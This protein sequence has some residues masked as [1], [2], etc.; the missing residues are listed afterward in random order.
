MKK[1]LAIIFTVLVSIIILVMGALHLVLHTEL[2]NKL[3]HRFTAEMIDGTARC[4]DIRLGLASWPEL[5]V[6][7]DSISVTYPHSRFASLQR[8]MDP[9]KGLEQDTLAA[10]AL[11]RVQASYEDLK[12]GRIAADVGISGLKAYALR[13]QD[14]RANWEM[15]HF[16]SS[17]QK[18][19]SS[20]M[21]YVDAAVSMEGSRL[22]YIDRPGNLALM[23]DVS[24]QAQGAHSAERTCL[25]VDMDAGRFAMHSGDLLL[26][27]K[28][29]CLIGSVD[30]SRRDAGQRRPEMRFHRRG[31]PVRRDSSLMASDIDI[32]LDESVSTLVQQWHPRARLSLG[33]GMVMTSALPLRSSVSDALLR[34]DS[35]SLV[36]DTLALRCGSSDLAVKGRVAGLSRT[37][38]GKGNGLW[39]V[40]LDLN[41]DRLNVNEILAALKVQMDSSAVSSDL[42]FQDESIF[43][44]AAVDTLANVDTLTKPKLI[45]VPANVVGSARLSANRVD[46]SQFDIDSLKAL[47]DIGGRCIQ[48][49]ELSASSSK[50]DI[51]HLDAYYYTRSKEDI[52][53]GFDIEVDNVDADKLRQIVPSLQDGI[54]PLKTF[55]G[56]FN[57]TAAATVKLDT[58]MCLLL[59]SMEGTAY[60]HADSLSIPDL[61]DYKK[62]ARLLLFRRLKDVRVHDLDISGT[63]S[64]SRMEVYPFLVG[65]DRYSFALCGDQNLDKNFNYR[66]TIIKSPM[67]L[68]LGA[69]LSGKAYTKVRFRLCKPQFKNTDVPVFYDEVDSLHLDLGRSVREVSALPA[70]K[71]FK[72]MQQAKERKSYSDDM[73]ELPEGSDNPLLLRRMNSPSIK[74]ETNSDR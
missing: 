21:P 24:L 66:G 27:L 6:E 71:M 30:D 38:F 63:I 13:Y 34:M 4:G 32:H 40:D 15:F 2:H 20:A 49:E 50:G 39:R 23:G 70:H 1:A 12:Q 52:G 73:E 18:D 60:L 35:D 22:A 74:L 53:A 17:G 44:E 14:G 46:F 65:V 69:K 16:P 56:N 62:Y 29:I 45:V 47:L 43:E 72:Y 11:L 42:D 25:D 31:T 68:R 3:I 37:L 58:N 8:R 28:D 9:G 57:C 36:V 61:G 59:P 51:R 55:C 67:P 19:S 26:L 41:S 54:A 5:S 64:E 10:I 48:V 33:K 7:I